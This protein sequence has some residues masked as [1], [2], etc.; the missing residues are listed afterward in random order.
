MELLDLPN[1]MIL[2][3]GE[4]L[5]SQGDIHAL[6]QGN[7]RLYHLLNHHLYKTNAERHGSTALLWAVEHLDAEIAR[8]ALAAGASVMATNARAETPLFLAVSQPR[9]YQMVELLLEN[10]AAATL[11]STPVP[12]IEA[13]SQNADI[14][15]V[16]LLLQHGAGVNEEDRFGATA[17]CWAA[18]TGQEVVTN[19]LIE[20][21]ARVNLDI[22]PVHPYPRVIGTPLLA[23]AAGGYERIV[24]LLI[25]HGADLHATDDFDGE[26]SLTKAYRRG[27]QAVINA[28]IEA[29]AREE[30]DDP[31]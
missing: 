28:L 24:Q 12:L 17:L 25:K 1:E 16:Q 20:A 14:A 13:V 11:D 9:S 18:D 7:K 3:I 10:G 21:G 8:K 6:S 5:A 27:H 26:D 19:L 30:Y 29:L 2:E 31:A 22:F 23:A 4:N 15:V